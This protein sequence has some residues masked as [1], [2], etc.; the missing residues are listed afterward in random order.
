MDVEGHDGGIYGWLVV[1]ASHVCS[2]FVFG[3]FQSIGPVFVALQEYFESSSSRT[4][5]IISVAFCLETAFGPV[6]NISVKKIGYRGTVILGGLVSSIGFLLTA[7]AP[8]LEFIYFSFGVLVG[9]GYGLI[10]NPRLGLIPFYI[11]KRFVI[12]NAIAVSGSGTGTFVFPPVWQLLI[13]TY[14]WRTAFIFFAAINAT[15]CVCGALF[16]LPKKSTGIT[17]VETSIQPNID[18]NSNCENDKEIGLKSSDQIS[19]LRQMV[20]ACDCSLFSKYPRLIVFTFALTL[21]FGIGFIGVPAHMVSRAESKDL[22]S[23]NNI[24]LVV[25]IFGVAGIVGRLSPPAILH[26]TPRTITSSRLFGLALLL[27][28]I[29]NILS[30]LADSYQM[31]CVYAA[32]LGL[33]IGVV[34]TMTSQAIKDIV[35]SSNLM[36]GLSIST[37]W[38]SLGS[39]GP[40]LAGWIY[41]I[42]QDYNNSFYFY[43][44]CMVFAGL[45]LILF[46]TLYPLCHCQGEVFTVNDAK[47]DANQNSI[48][49]MKVST[50][51]NTE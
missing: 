24:A 34:A 42:T 32:I 18:E 27:G 26:F 36:A 11:K 38:T 49:V 50:G 30:F 4:A 1:L 45:T 12:A 25:S 21:G 44:S 16:R 3:M 41:D 48:T 23:E 37:P 9:C 51:T 43:G 8:S 2:M 47:Y 10:V 15:L 20:K 17:A 7:F 46:E 39:F 29:T 5:W 19:A 14:G 6:A 22:S 28:G 35:G 33:L 31:Y 40:P 13:E